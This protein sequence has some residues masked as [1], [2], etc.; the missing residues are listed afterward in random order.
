MGNAPAVM[1]AQS[2]VLATG[3][4]S[5]SDVESEDLEVS[6]GAYIRIGSP[7]NLNTYVIESIDSVGTVC[8]KDVTDDNEAPVFLSLEEAN[9]LYNRYIRY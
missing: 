5:A 7:P 1:K 9:E 3:V 6:V 2:V 8:C 4:S